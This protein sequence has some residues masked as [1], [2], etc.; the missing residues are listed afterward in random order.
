MGSGMTIRPRVNT[1]SDES[2]IAPAKNPRQ[3]PPIRAPRRNVTATQAT[4]ARAE[5]SR[6][7][8]SFTPKTFIEAA[9]VQ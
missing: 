7:A 1:P 4:V 9:I 8:N 5:G 6:A 3:V 2:R